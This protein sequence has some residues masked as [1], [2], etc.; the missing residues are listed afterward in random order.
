MSM[1]AENW[2]S[3]RWVHPEVCK[4]CGIAS[5]ADA[6]WE[7]GGGGTFSFKIDKKGGHES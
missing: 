5:S 7:Q 6:A 3:S 2:Q 4:Q 1:I